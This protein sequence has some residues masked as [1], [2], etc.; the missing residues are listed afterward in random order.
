MRR[1][2][3]DERGITIAEVMVA[4]LVMVLLALAVLGIGQAASRNTYRA[5]Q[6]QVVVNRL[7]E[8]LEHVRQLPYDEIALTSP[9]STSTDPMSPAHRVSGTQFALNRE[10]TDPKLLA[11]N[12]GQTPSGKTVSGGSIVS[13]DDF[14]SGDVSGK[15]YRYVVYPGAPANCANCNGDEVKRAIIAISLDSTG[16]GGERAYQEI[17]SDF[18]DPDKTSGGNLP[19][20]G[21]N[22]DPNIATF[23]LTDTPCSQ[24]VRQPLAGHHPAHN[25]RG[26]CSDGMQTGPTKG[27]PDLMFNEQPPD[28]DAG[29]STLFDYATDPAVEPV[30]NPG[31][32]IGLNL[33]EPAGNGC[34]ASAPLASTLDL[35]L[36]EGGTPDNRHLKTHLWLSNPLSEQFGLLDSAHAA[37]QLWTKSINGAS[38]SGKIC[39]WLF[40]RIT[41]LNALGQQ[42][43]VDVPA[44]NVD[45]PLVNALYFTYTKPTWPT[46][47]TELS[48]PMNMIWASNLPSNQLGPP[49]LGLAIQVERAGTNA[50]GIEF[51]YDHPDFES[52]LEV[53]TTDPILP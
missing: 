9:P 17:Q 39:I 28:S 46:Q 12:G 41:Y 5:E 16:S 37:L 51:M 45:P 52:R 8:E 53:Q 24:S 18:S 10:G 44:V 50:P 15:I 47:W 11:I 6:S 40:K 48:I 4:A 30:Q 13:T 43:V 42:V 32:D 26:V 7:Q 35:P 3:R 14:E 36:G 19:D 2:L 27:S 1:A 23:W 29:T 34:L 49:R 20:P 25:T 33:L 22:E 31:S 38:Y 21:G